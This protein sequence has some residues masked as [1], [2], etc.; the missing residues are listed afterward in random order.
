VGTPT[1]E[2]SLEVAGVVVSGHGAASGRGSVDHPGGT[3][4]EQIPLF[5]ERGLDLRG[6]HRGTVNVDIA[7]LR[8]VVVDPAFTFS[9]VAWTD[10]IPPET[11]SFLHC[12]LVVDGE[13][14]P[15]WVYVPHPETKVEHHQAPSVVEVI[16]GFV[17]GLSPG[18]VVRLVLDHGEADLTPA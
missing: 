17:E 1:P 8:L 15:G 9:D 13:S 18:T 2:G 10:R 14:H 16:A 4:A 12:A 7:P 11:F 5:L 3:L 6:F